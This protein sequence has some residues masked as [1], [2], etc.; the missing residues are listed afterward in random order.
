VSRKNR[1]L[2]CA[3]QLDWEK[4]SG[5]SIEAAAKE[6]IEGIVDCLPLLSKLKFSETDIQRVEEFFSRVSQD[7]QSHLHDIP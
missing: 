1:V 5:E 4:F 7:L 3:P 2:D 6:Y